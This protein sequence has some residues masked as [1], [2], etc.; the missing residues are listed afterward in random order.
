MQNVPCWGLQERDGIQCSSLH[1][2]NCL[3]IW[4]CLGKFNTDFLWRIYRILL[5]GFKVSSFILVA[6]GPL[7]SVPFCSVFCLI[8]PLWIVLPSSDSEDL[9]NQR[10]HFSWCSVVYTMHLRICYWLFQFTGTILTMAIIK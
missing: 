5:N 9:R 7:N 3:R 4:E 10:R 2:D 1:Y 8:V 6:V